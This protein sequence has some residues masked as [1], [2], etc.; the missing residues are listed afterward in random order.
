MNC[1]N[2]ILFIIKEHFCKDVA[3]ARRWRERYNYA[4]M[5]SIC[6]VTC[7][8]WSH[9]SQVYWNRS[10]HRTFPWLSDLFHLLLF[11]VSSHRNRRISP[12]SITCWPDLLVFFF[13][14][15]ESYFQ[16]PATNFRRLATQG[17]SNIQHSYK[18]SAGETWDG[19][20]PLV[21]SAQ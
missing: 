19:P 8:L 7:L 9:E 1:S 13:H 18:S 12:L 2:E 17:I 3:F 21:Y 10:H 20:L 14:W 6:S 5:K 4:V 15:W 11:I 16:H